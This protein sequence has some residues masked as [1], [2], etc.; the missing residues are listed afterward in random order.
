MVLYYILVS[1]SDSSQTLI[2][3]YSIHSAPSNP[4][5]RPLSLSKKS[6]LRADG[7]FD[8]YKALTKSE[9]FMY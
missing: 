3:L 1:S 5:S 4:L 2:S 8:M 7:P 6:H 9:N